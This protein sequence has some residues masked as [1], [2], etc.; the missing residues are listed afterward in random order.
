MDAVKK[1]IKRN[2]STRETI[3]S[4]SPG[5]TTT[6]PSLKPLEPGELYADLTPGGWETARAAV[7][8]RPVP[9]VCPQCKG[10][11]VVFPRPENGVYYARG[12]AIKAVPCPLCARDT[13]QDWLANHSGLEGGERGSK[14]HD[15][16]AIRFKERDKTA[17]RK[18]AKH[19]IEQ[20]IEER[21][22][23]YSFWGDF[24]SGKSLALRIIVN[25]MRVLHL[26]EGYYASFAAI[27]DHLRGLFSRRED[28]GTYWDRL[29]RIPVLALDEVTRFDDRGW[30]LDKLFVLVDT[31]YR[32]KASHLTIFATND[33][34]R[35]ALPPEDGIGYLFSRMREGH[36]CELRG[37]VRSV[38]AA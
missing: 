31:R 33:D 8:G 16:R 15:F 6:N 2:T 29:L 30:I 35:K 26:Q 36:L 19:L 21:H 25:E 34:P 23:L 10:T 3:P 14:M 27:I 18:Q 28:V 37:D 17:Q 12:A 32:L 5:Y 11:G 7:A 38:V 4:A 20:A 1:I 22:G 9:I 13:R 24:G